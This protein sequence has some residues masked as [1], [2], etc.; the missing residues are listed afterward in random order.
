MDEPVIERISSAFR[1]RFQSEPSLV[2]CAPGR[3]NLIGEHTDYNDGFVMPLAIDRAVWVAARP[4][5][6]GRVCLHSLNYARDDEFALD[7]IARATG[8]DGWSNYVRGVAFMLRQAGYAVRGMDAVVWGDVPV[9][10]GLS[11][12]AAVQVATLIAFAGISGFAVDMV[13]AARLAQRSEIEFVGVNCGIMDQ[14]IAA[15]GQA[16]HALLIDCRSLAYRAVPIPSGAAIVV[17]D[18]MK[19][20][21][22][23]DSQYNTRRAECEQGARALGVPSLR[24]V[25]LAEFERRSAELPEPVRSRCRHVIGENVRVERCV[26]AL[27][28]DDLAGAGALLNQ[29]HASLRDD[30]AVS[31]RELDIMVAAAQALPGVY[32]AR[33]TGAGFGG[34]TVNLVARNQADQAATDLAA[35]YKAQTGIEAHIYVCQAVDGAH[36]TRKTS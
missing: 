6:D 36:I 19:R 20:R 9:G 33:M 21:E 32:G 8:A 12:S 23:V 15:L 13:D 2:A 29:S 7:G 22:L 34:C 25:P 10:S 35:S 14:M 26:V 28:A 24:D 30:Y 5:A 18:T 11:S 1:A 16:G 27:E 31:C 3:V 17:A 4:R